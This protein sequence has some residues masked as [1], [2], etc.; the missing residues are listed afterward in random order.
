[1]K[2]LLLYFTNLSKG[3]N[4]N[5]SNANKMFFVSLLLE[6]SGKVFIIIDSFFY[7]KIINVE[8]E[9]SSKVYLK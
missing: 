2:S 1:M 5:A 8:N 7:T 3:C 9:I 6:C 4:V